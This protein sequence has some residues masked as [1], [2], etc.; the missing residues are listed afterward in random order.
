[1]ISHWATEGCISAIRGTRRRILPRSSPPQP[2]EDRRKL[3]AIA[4]KFTP[5]CHRKP[6]MSKLLSML[7]I[8]FVSGVSGAHAASLTI[9]ETN[10]LGTDDG[11]NGNLLVA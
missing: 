3:A 10:V 4:V 5:K 6:I 11:G 8:G 1:M 9:G 7:V 2:P